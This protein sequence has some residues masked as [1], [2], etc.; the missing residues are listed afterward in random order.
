MF[1]IRKATLLK[2]LL[3]YRDG[4]QYNLTVNEL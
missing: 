3:N 2:Q 1:G 4:A